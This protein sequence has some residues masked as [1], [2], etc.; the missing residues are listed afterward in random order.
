[1]SHVR[2]CFVLV[3]LILAAASLSACGMAVEEGSDTATTSAAI[4]APY[5]CPGYYPF[6]GESCSGE[7]SCGLTTA[8]RGTATLTCSGS[9]WYVQDPDGCGPL[10]ANAPPPDMTN[11]P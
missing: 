3:N 4:T 6:D 7:Y 11:C 1:M 10:D 9:V 2:P 5:A 8:C